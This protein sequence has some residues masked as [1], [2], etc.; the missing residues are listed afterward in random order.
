MCNICTYYIFS[1]KH[2][3][4]HTFVYVCVRCCRFDCCTTCRHL[5]VRAFNV[6]RT[7]I[8]PPEAK[9]GR[10]CT[11]C[12]YVCMYMHM[13]ISAYMYICVHVRCGSIEK[14]LRSQVTRITSIPPC[15]ALKRLVAYC[16]VASLL[17]CIYILLYL[18]LW[19]VN[20]RCC[21]CCYPCWSMRAIPYKICC[22]V[23]RRCCNC[24]WCCWCCRCRL[25]LFSLLSTLCTRFSRLGL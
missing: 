4:I 19:F 20:V 21:V 25:C 16:I 2:A 14:L 1:Y 22:A 6:L 10:T 3:Y 13:F 5:L 24:C 17:F 18:Y 7:S 15:V 12:T 23:N 11:A 8:A 9:M